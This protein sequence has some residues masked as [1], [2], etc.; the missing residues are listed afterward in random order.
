MSASEEPPFRIVDADAA[1]AAAEA[2]FVVVSERLARM[3]PGSAQ[4]LH[5]G[6]TSVPGCLTKGDFDIVVRVAPADFA[7]ADQILACQFARNEGSLRTDTF[8][9]FEDAACE[10][11]LGVQLAAIGGPSDVFHRFAEALRRSPALLEAYNALKREY[12]GAEMQSYRNAKDV[13]I[14]SALSLPVAQASRRGR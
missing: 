14:A 7:A 3:L 10:P 13:F 12:D 1:R 2:L 9:G 11:H 8:S 4:V 6:A 5:V